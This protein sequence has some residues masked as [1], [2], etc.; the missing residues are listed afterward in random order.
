MFLKKK[1]RFFLVIIF[2]WG[3]IGNSFS[4]EPDKF[5]QLTVDEASEALRSAFA[6]SN[7]PS[8]AD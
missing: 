6:M 7:A 2:F 5:V 1:L 3:Y 4:I 8:A